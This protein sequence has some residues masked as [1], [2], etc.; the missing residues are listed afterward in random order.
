M[1][2]V[3]TKYIVRSVNNLR[4]AKGWGTCPRS[5]WNMF[6]LFSYF[7]KATVPT[8]ARMEICHYST[9]ST[10]AMISAAKRRE[11]LFQSTDRKT[12]KFKFVRQSLPLRIRSALWIP[13]NRGDNTNKRHRKSPARKTRISW[14]LWIPCTAAQLL[15]VRCPSP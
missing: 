10:S 13:C 1:G 6:V 15:F 3:Y 14:A 4:S 7:C 2:I 12:E 8:R 9:P 11:I 5:I